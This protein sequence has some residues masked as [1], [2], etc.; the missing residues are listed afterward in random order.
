MPDQSVDPLFEARSEELQKVAGHMDEI[1]SYGKIARRRRRASVAQNGEWENKSGEVLLSRNHL[2]LLKGLFDRPHS[3]A[4][5]RDDWIAAA[6]PYARAWRG[7]LPLY[8]CLA[9]SILT[10]PKTLYDRDRISNQVFYRLRLRGRDILEG[11][12]S[13]WVIGVGRYERS[14][15]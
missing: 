13:V 8:W 15:H 12:A 4:S 5:S 10:L 1:W 9:K 3:M 6:A 2:A 14:P 11:R 7:D